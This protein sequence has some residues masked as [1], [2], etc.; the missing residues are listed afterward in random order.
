M[1]LTETQQI[2]KKI[3]GIR[4][5]GSEQFFLIAGPCVV[6]GEEITFKTAEKVKFLADKFKIPLLFKSSYR[7][8]N[9]SKLDSFTGLG[10]EGALKI[11]GK[12]RSEL[13]V[14]VI[15][16]IHTPPEAAMAAEYVDALQIPAFLCRQTELL[17]AA[18]ATGKVINIKKGQFLAP[19]SMK[20]AVEKVKDTGNNKILLTERGSMFGYGDLI[21]D[22][23][24][25]SEM[26]ESGQPVILDVTH[27]LQQP[28]QPTGVSGG[29]PEMIG[30]MA[31][32]GIAAGVDGI[33]LET[34]PDPTKALS[35]GSNML[36]LELLEEL[37]EQLTELRKLI[38][39]LDI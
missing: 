21:V 6:E 8:A 28:N 7:K 1:K 19:S 10:D 34:H 24:G 5:S 37:L 20:F 27:S 9:R 15:T 3:P 22:F 26:Q 18:G 2:L 38:V 29:R 4:Y 23:R 32:T 31:R 36:H 39:K 16:D 14:P 13:K 12:V 33:F 25:I 11:L 17:Q 35:D 30:L